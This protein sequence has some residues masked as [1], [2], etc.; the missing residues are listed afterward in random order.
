MGDSFTEGQGAT[1]WFYELEKDF[2][3]SVIKPVNLGI[4]GTG[5]R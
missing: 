1:P 5:P 4:L 3:G 2:S